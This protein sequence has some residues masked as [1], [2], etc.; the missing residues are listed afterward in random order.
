M[1]LPTV[2]FASA[3]FSGPDGLY[4]SLQGMTFFSFEELAAALPV[5]DEW[6]KEPIL[7]PTDPPAETAVW[8]ALAAS[9]A[10][11]NVT[12]LQSAHGALVKMA[13]G[14]QKLDPDTHA[15]SAARVNRRL[16]ERFLYF[17]SGAAA[18][19]EALSGIVEPADPHK[20]RVVF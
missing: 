6:L 11:N 13:E 10:S 8:N 2:N 5:F 14:L 7:E 16:V 4:Q 12:L 3:T 20:T 19:L 17:S 18:V 15:R 1:Y 9:V